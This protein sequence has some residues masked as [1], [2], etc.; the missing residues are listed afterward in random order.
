[1]KFVKMQGAGNDFIVLDNREGRI[2]KEAYGSLAKELCC[3]RLS[4]GADGMM[5]VEKAC[6]AGDYRM[7]FYNADGSEGEMCGNGARCIARYGHDYLGAGDCQRVET[8]S[9]T[10]IGKRIAAERYRVRLND[11]SRAEKVAV[12]TENGVYSG[13]YLEMGVPGLPHGIIRYDDWDK[14][15]ANSL[16]E[17]GRMLRLASCFPKGA[18]ITFWTRLGENRAKCITFERGVEDFTLACGTGAGCTASALFM[19]GIMTEMPV[20]LEFPGG[21]LEVELTVDNGSISDIYLTGPTKIVAEGEC[22]P[23]T[24]PQD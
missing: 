21:V 4:I 18:N 6:C 3:R 15:D 9:G 13:W 19:D 5:I 7:S 23:E 14:T 11:L 24:V 2:A 16:R 10:V 20:F 1:M 17:L 22:F 8:V 12:E